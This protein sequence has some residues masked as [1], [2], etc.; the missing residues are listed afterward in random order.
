MNCLHLCVRE[1]QINRI[2]LLYND[3]NDNLLNNEDI[4]SE[5][6]RFYGS[7]LGSSA[8]QLPMIDLPTKIWLHSLL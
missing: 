7:L 4:Q 1:D 6:L 5:A 8:S 3:Q 2:T